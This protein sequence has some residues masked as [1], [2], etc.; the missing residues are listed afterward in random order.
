MNEPRPH[1]FLPAEEHD[2]DPAETA[3]WRDALRALVAAQ[4]VE[5]ACPRTAVSNL[6]KTFRH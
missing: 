3:E 5:R 1:R 2:S 6:R 4:G